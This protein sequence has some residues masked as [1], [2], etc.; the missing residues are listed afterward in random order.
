MDILKN[1]LKNKLKGMVGMD[2]K[3]EESPE[4]KQDEKKTAILDAYCQV[5]KKNEA[6]IQKIVNENLIEF[7]KESFSDVKQ[8]TKKY[9]MNFVIS[10]M[11]ESKILDDYKIKHRLF[12]NIINNDTEIQN[13]VK[14]YDWRIQNNNID[15]NEFIKIFDKDENDKKINGGDNQNVTFN[16]LNIFKKSPN[17]STETN[18]TNIN[19]N[20]IQEDIIISD[21]SS[22]FS[23]QDEQVNR[24]IFEIIKNSIEKAINKSE[25]IQNELENLYQT[26][27]IPYYET[28]ITNITND[29]HLNKYIFVFLLKDNDITN[30]LISSIKDFIIHKEE[31]PDIISVISKHFKYPPVSGGKYSKTRKNKN[32]KIRKNKKKTRR[33]I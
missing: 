27:I 33:T 13:I 24:E 30:K 8:D 3:T 20:N 28:F 14:N 17:T 32:K 23:K 31:N 26:Q 11:N 1:K 21:I 12:Y 6:N 18:E 10:K 22:W 29:I 4:I 5:I 19:Q 7:F 2:T 15:L 9:I 16:P 25:I